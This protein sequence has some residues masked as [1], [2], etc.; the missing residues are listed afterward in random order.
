[1]EVHH[2]A[3]T[4]RKKW[5]HYFW[6]FLMLFLAVF[7]GFMAENFREHKVEHH[8]EKQYMETMVEDL[9]KDTANLHTSISFWSSVDSAIKKCRP[10]LKPPADKRNVRDIYSL[11]SSLINFDAFIYNDRTIQQLRNSGSFRLIRNKEVSESIITYDAYIRNQLRDQESFEKEFL[12]TILSYQ[13]ELFDSE[14]IEAILTQQDVLTDSLLT[15]S[16]QNWQINNGLYFKYYN[17]LLLY[18]AGAIYILNT[19]KDLKQKAVA[20]ITLIKKEYHLD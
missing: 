16:T 11:A 7:C 4:A 17:E 12:L 6:E 20:L 3:H 15:K 9:E 2:H 13:N 1:M 18:Q 19:E 14:I 8:R 10:L 5:T